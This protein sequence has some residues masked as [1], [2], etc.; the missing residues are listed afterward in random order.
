MSFPFYLYLLLCVSEWDTVKARLLLTMSV[1]T[2]RLGVLECS[3]LILYRE[4]LVC[5]SL[6]FSLF[7]GYIAGSACPS[8]FPF[9]DILFV[10]DLFHYFFICSMSSMC[11]LYRYST[12]IPRYPWGSGNRHTCE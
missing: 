2:E 4:S 10:T 6:D 9:A 7:R 8:T 12:A 5:D 1:V 11:F 3:D